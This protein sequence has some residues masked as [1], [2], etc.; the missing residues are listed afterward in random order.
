M[1]ILRVWVGGLR[2]RKA[3]SPCQVITKHKIH[4]FKTPLF[5]FFTQK[6]TPKF[7]NKRGHLLAS[8]NTRTSAVHCCKYSYITFS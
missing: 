4:Q 6:N 5:L 2:F 8:H 3:G 7:A 1:R